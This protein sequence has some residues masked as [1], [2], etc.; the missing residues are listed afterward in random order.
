MAKQAAPV[1][2]TGGEGF[3]YEDRVA[4]RFLI[5]ML[6]GIV[7]FGVEFGFITK[8]DWQARDT[9]RLLDDLLV[10][11]SNKTGL[12]IA[13]LSIKKHRQVTSGGFPANFVEACWEEWLHTKTSIFENDRDLLVLVTGEI[14]N[15]VDETWSTLLRQARATSP[16]RLISRLQVPAPDDGSQASET[17]REMFTSLQCPKVLLSQGQ[18]DDKAAVEMLRRIRLLS[19]DFES[20]PSRD[21][22]RAVA[23]CQRLLKD[24]SVGEG[25]SLWETLVGI[26]A[27]NRGMG[28]SL[29]LPSLVSELRATF[30][31]VDHPDFAS[32]WSAIRQSSDDVLSD[33]RSEIGANTSIDRE[34]EANAIAN[35]LSTLRVCLAAG[36]S[37]CGKSALAKR[38]SE[39]FY[40][41]T[42]AIL[43]EDCEVERLKQLDGKLGITHPLIEVLSSSRDRCLLVLDSLE[44]YSERGLRIAG[45]LVSEVLADRRCSHVDVLLL[46]QYDAT[47]RVVTRLS[48]AG[49]DQSRL[50]I[51]PIGS[52]PDLAI[53]QVLQD[54]AGIAWVTLHIEMR[55][56]LRNLKILDWVVRASQSGRELGTANLSGLI[57]LID[58]LWSRWIESDDRGIAGGG[59]LKKIAVIEAS[60]LA[61]GVPLTSL[62]YS[63]QQALNSLMSADLL[64][65]RS[66]RIKF[67]HDLLGDWARLR[68][69]IGDDP[70]VSRE[71]IQRIAMARWHRA[72]RLFGRWL[73]SQKDGVR[74]WSEAVRRTEENGTD[75][76]TVIRDLLLESV[77]V[78]ENS[79]A[80]LS[81]AW[82]VLIENEGRLLKFLLD[83]FMFTATIPD[84]RLPKLVKNGNVAPQVEVAFRVPL[85]PYWGAVLA[86]LNEHCAVVCRLVPSEAAR[87]CK[88]WLEKTPSEIAPG[89]P[90]P[91][92]DHAAKAALSLAR[93]F[94]ALRAEGKYQHDAEEQTAYQ[95]AL[96][97]AHELPDEVSTFALEMARRRPALQ[98]VQERAEAAK[99]AAE[100][101]RRQWEEGNPDRVEQLRHL[102]E[103]PLPLGDLVGPW[104]DGPT[105][106]VEDAFREAVF[107]N[108]A[109]LPLAESRPDTAFEVLLA[110]CIEPPYHENPYGSDLMD[111]CGLESWR[112]HDPAIY[113]QGPFL[114]LFRLCPRQGIDFTLKLINFATG[115]WAAKELRS[116]QRR[117][118]ASPDL[119]GLIEVDDNLEVL[120]QVEADAKSWIGDR[121][122]FRWYLDW[123]VDCRIIPCVLMALEKWIYEQIDA[124]QD[125]DQILREIV[126]RSESVAFAGLLIDVGKR[127]PELFL[128]C[129][130]PLLSAST[131]Y[132]WEPR[133][134]MERS[135]T[136]VGLMGWWRQPQDLVTLARE[137]HLAPHRKHELRRIAIWLMFMSSE[138]E[139]FFQECRARWTQEIETAQSPDD[140]QILI[141]VFDRSN[142]REELVEGNKIRSEFVLPG[143]LAAKAQEDVKR[144]D[145][146]MRLMGFPMECRRI[147]DGEK[148]LLAADCESFWDTAR[149]IEKQSVAG[150]DDLAKKAAAVSGAVAVLVNLHLDWIEGDPERLSWCLQQLQ[151]IIDNPPKRRQFDVP[152][153]A[154]D[155]DW[156]CFV[157]EAG[158][159]L[160]KVAPENLFIRD[161]V[162]TGIAG[163]HYGT[164]QKTMTL[165][166]RYR[167]SLG[168]DFELMQYLAIRWSLVR[169]LRSQSEHYLAEATHWRKTD[170]A[171]SSLSEMLKELEAVA[172][173]WRVEHIRIVEQFISREPHPT[174]FAD[175]GHIGQE[176]VE[177]VMCI[178]FPSR[179]QQ[180]RPKQATGRRRRTRRKDRGIDGKVVSA[181]FSWVSE[182][183]PISQS[184]CRQCVSRVK[185]LVD[186][187]LSCIQVDDDDDADG[188]PGEFDGWVFGLAARAIVAMDDKDDPASVWK[189]ILSLNEEAHDWIGR[190]FWYWFSDGYQ[191]TPDT[192]TFFL[193]WSEMITFALSAAEWD[194]ERVQSFGLDEMVFELMGYHFGMHSIA[195]DPKCADNLAE[196]LPLL[197]AAAQKWFSMPR[198]VNGFARSLSEPG[199]ERILCHGVRWLHR[200]MP[201]SSDYQFWRTH[202]IESNL[203]SALH[204]CWEKHNQA[205]CTERD[206]QTAFLGLLT[207][208]SSRGNHAA[209]ALRDRLLD[210]LPDD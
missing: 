180:P 28:G 150:Q 191:A 155:W 181:A 31:L 74:R 23:D 171:D 147:L 40:D 190:F 134:L 25:Q 151:Q 52:P 203:I 20:D 210:S 163:F 42:V 154:G 99:V 120:V 104:P 49:V 30:Q 183:L 137:W 81:M 94:Q 143:N 93:E 90:F 201:S 79:R 24:S 18:T 109:I 131:F 202:G 165:A 60:G 36:E 101:K 21:L 8:I 148:E 192:N 48:E 187:V 159:G 34:Q 196:M 55:P 19:F 95:A 139:T 118:P 46:M 198:V 172:E 174:T 199:Y 186:V 7:P 2:L 194:P 67:S 63:E 136:P 193:R 204:R 61:A 125:V 72:V 133:I 176:E 69:L 84:L 178:R 4:A 121:R 113:Y 82:P 96:L 29:D 66:E 164:T 78:S 156:D 129:L 22:A 127:K 173:R 167:Q 110:V 207:A 12:H 123:P 77:V 205:V 68:V 206:L 10:T 158:V 64:K 5:D 85:W 126:G 149:Q 53:K 146:S 184:E 27:E 102:G 195:A 76:G 11:M 97:A 116:R 153:S 3:N 175:V 152:N 80:L 162:A 89:T 100:V 86:T 144:A 182:A 200:A 45:R 54:S 119:A 135:A 16:D 117:G 209:M 170:N 140:L 108:S 58:Y 91:F 185:D 56:L 44:R 157:A 39:D 130:R 65:R 107:D 87:V 160:L 122:V 138:M 145:D 208:L 9:G 13:E 62:E 166:H 14:A 83:R 189:P 98:E 179:K 141:A 188:L 75:E 57:S 51:T 103:S 59:L 92:R 15:D 112:D 111:D 17:A 177:A 32:D 197:D 142:Y 50:D 41:A 106:H 115:R 43:P 168:D 33:V 114:P 161:L 1:E 169:R 70:T 88:L 6:S 38:V 124:E 71:G 37:G 35:A 105:E 26:A 128:T 47:Q 73:L 132:L